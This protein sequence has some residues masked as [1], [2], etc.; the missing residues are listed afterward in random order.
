ME[1]WQNNAFPDFHNVRKLVCYFP[2]GYFFDRKDSRFR[3]VLECHLRKK[4][5]LL[6]VAVFQQVF[7][8]GSYC[9]DNRGLVGVEEES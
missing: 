2:L 1:M 7:F 5:D 6:R 9:K 8:E 4:V 3:N